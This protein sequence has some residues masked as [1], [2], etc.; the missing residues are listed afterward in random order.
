MKT[1]KPSPQLFA[2]A[3]AETHGTSMT[4]RHVELSS[5]RTQINRFDC[6]R[7]RADDNLFGS[8]TGE[9]RL[10][11]ADEETILG[12]YCAPTC[13]TF[14]SLHSLPIGAQRPSTN[15]CCATFREVP[16]MQTNA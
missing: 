11:R 7:R 6:G 14:V 16:F 8:D 1:D 9:L 12:S 3:V 15:S 10:C 13:D 5:L 4:F 2:Q